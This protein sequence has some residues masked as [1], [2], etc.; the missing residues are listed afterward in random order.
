MPPQGDLGPDKATTR[1]TAGSGLR[2]FY[3]E[4]RPEGRGCTNGIFATGWPKRRDLKGKIARLAKSAEN[5]GK[6]KAW[7]G[8]TAA[9][10]RMSPVRAGDQLKILSVDANLGDGNAMDEGMYFNFARADAER[11]MNF[12]VVN[13]PAV[14]TYARITEYCE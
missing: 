5:E 8:K 14:E 2:R 6:M 13:G 4:V 1:A 12:A 3:R 10:E 9:M 7:R 11:A